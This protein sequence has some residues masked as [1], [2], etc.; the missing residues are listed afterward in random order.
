MEINQKG[1]LVFFSGKMGAGKSTY[2]KKI[3]TELNAILLSEDEWLSS[4]YPEEIKIFED[5][6]K[7]S[8]RLKPLLRTHIQSI[9]NSGLSVVLDF[10]GNT[11]KQRAWF[12]EIFTNE[13]IPHKLIYLKAENQ[14]CLKRLEKRRQTFPERSKFDNEEV[15]NQVTSYFQEPTEDEGFNMEVIEQ[16]I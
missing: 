3:A 7:Y 6:I 11:I 12:K 16:S 13:N 15:F 14:I 4:I 10:P 2:S 8:A 1:T 9:L 5:Y